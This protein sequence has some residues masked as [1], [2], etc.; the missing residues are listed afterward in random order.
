MF[1]RQFLLVS[2]LAA[3]TLSTGT[4][5]QSADAAP[6][7]K[8]FFQ[9]VAGS[10]SGPGEIVAGK[11]KG[12]KFSCSLTGKPLDGNNAGVKLDGTCRVGVFQ[13]PMS[14][15]ITQSGGS[16]SGKFLDGAA[17]KGLDITSGTVNDGT[18]VLGLIRQKLNGAMIARVSDNKSMNVTISVKVGEQMVPVIGVTLKRADIDQMA[19]GS[20]Q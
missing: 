7:D 2:G 12:T 6:R 19:V 20:I 16:Y 13:Q 9:S 10:W 3:A 5:V 1:S 14:A 8:A 11:Y 15:E 18:V 17:G 4:W